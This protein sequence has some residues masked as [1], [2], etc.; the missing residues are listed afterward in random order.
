MLIVEP[1]L[2][3]P[4]PKIVYI[5]K[6]FTQMTGYSFEDLED[7]TPRVLQGKESNRSIG[8]TLKDKMRN[9]ES[10]SFQTVNYKKDGTKYDVKINI[11]PIKDSDGNIINYA[12]VQ[13]DI[14]NH[15]E[16]VNYL[17][18]F[19]DLQDNMIILTDGTKLNFANKRLFDFFGFENLDDFTSIHQCICERFIEDDRFFNLTKVKE[20]ENWVDVL[21]TLPHSKRI[22]TMLGSDFKIHAFAITVNVFDSKMDIVTFSNISQTVLNQINLHKKTIHDKLTGAFNREYFEQNYRNLIDEYQSSGNSFGLAL[23]D[24]DHFKSVNDT[25]GHD[26][27]DYVLKHMVELVQKFSRTEDILIRWGGEEFVMIL[28]VKSLDALHK[29]LEHIRQ[30][31]ELEEFDTVKTITCSFGAA[32]YKNNEDIEETIKRADDALYFSKRTGRN[33]VTVNQ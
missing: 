30:V 26:V 4:G 32:V 12:S 10:F 18:R 3:F 22:V 7:K 14:S 23:L 2:E 21:K 33:K 24:I 19:I 16:T 15:V 9:G 6:A 11:F 1:Q 27:G 29:A 17:Q 28:N 25:Y 31:I 5:N 8:E 20:G 13:E